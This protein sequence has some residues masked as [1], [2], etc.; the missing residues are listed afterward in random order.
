MVGTIVS[1][2]SYMDY[3]PG[4]DLIKKNNVRRCLQNVQFTVFKE[5][6]FI[7]ATNWRTIWQKEIN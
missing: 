4:M 7:I 2:A 3:E 6:K 1:S 5:S